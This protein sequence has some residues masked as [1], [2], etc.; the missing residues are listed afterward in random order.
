MEFLTLLSDF[1]TTWKGRTS[2][3]PMTFPTGQLNLGNGGELQSRHNIWKDCPF[4]TRFINSKMHLLTNSMSYGTRK[5]NAAFIKTPII[6]ILS[7]IN[8]IPRI[9]T[10]FFKVYF[11]RLPN[12][13]FPVG[14]PDKILKALLSCSILAT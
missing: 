7:R 8:P 2:S 1:V 9:D 13:L 11:N 10:Y 3:R 14:L 6:P 5:F 12:G 4:R